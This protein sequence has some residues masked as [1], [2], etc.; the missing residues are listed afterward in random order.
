VG[1]VGVCR[2][3]ACDS[4][5]SDHGVGTGVNDTML[6]ETLEVITLV[7]SVTRVFRLKKKTM[8]LCVYEANLY[9]CYLL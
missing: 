2:L 9:V 6:S 1:R 8:N 7:E 5:E 4:D 3:C